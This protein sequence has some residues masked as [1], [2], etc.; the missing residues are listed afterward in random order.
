MNDASRARAAPG[1]GAAASERAT[2]RAAEARGALDLDGPAALGALLPLLLLPSFA[3][4]P[5]RPW[6]LPSAAPPPSAGGA[7]MA[8]SS[9][10]TRE[11]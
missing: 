8:G 11:G 3:G 4:A 2:A 5:A 7:D 10:W 1:A 6:P 9:R